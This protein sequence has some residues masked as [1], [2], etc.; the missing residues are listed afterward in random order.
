MQQWFLPVCPPGH[1]SVLL[2][3]LFCNWLLLV[4]Y[5]S[6]FFS[7]CR[8]LVN[9]SCIFSTVFPRSWIIFTTIILNSFSE[10]LPISTSLSCFSEVLSCPFFH[11]FLLFHC[12]KLSVKKKEGG[13]FG[14]CGTVF[15]LASSVCPLMDK[16]KR[17]V[18]ASQGLAGG[19]TGFCSGGQGLAQ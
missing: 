7:S 19:K 17:L 10:R 8:S 9:V 14:H 11:N 13:C 15:P 12:D 3:L 6:L 2:S 1:S 5:S 4:Y 18:Q 16:D